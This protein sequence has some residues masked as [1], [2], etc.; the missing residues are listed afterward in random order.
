[1]GKKEDWEKICQL[2]QLQS[3]YKSSL[4]LSEAVKGK[5]PKK[6]NIIGVNWAQLTRAIQGT[7]NSAPGPDKIHI[8]ML[9]H[10]PPE[11]LDPHVALWKKI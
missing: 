6:G 3:P 11:G 5:P 7:K 9:K 8:Q 2:S 1:M 4:E 10:L